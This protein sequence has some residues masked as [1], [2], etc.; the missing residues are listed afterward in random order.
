[1]FD[2]QIQKPDLLWFK[3][4]Y[5]S[6]QKSKTILWKKKNPEWFSHKTSE[7]LGCHD[8]VVIIQRKL[9]FKKIGSEQT[10]SW[11]DTPWCIFD[12]LSLFWVHWDTD[13]LVH[14]YKIIETSIVVWFV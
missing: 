4:N 9:M 10:W 14:H 3:K 11:S 12:I 1:M 13:R 5:K 6:L 8:T 7:P 2:A